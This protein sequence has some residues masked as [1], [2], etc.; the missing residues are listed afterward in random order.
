MRKSEILRCIG[1]EDTGGLVGGSR[2]LLTIM[3]CCISF[4]NLPDLY[5]G[6]ARGSRDDKM[7][8]G[9]VGLAQIFLLGTFSQ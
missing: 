6:Q 2:F 7:S 9:V 3:N 8:A 5:S 1:V 4:S